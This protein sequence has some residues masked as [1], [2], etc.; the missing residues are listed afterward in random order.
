MPCISMEFAIL[1]TMSI[2]CVQKLSTT[3]DIVYIVCKFRQHSK[4]TVLNY[5]HAIQIASNEGVF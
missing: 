5:P 4:E 2:G 1:S 3:Q